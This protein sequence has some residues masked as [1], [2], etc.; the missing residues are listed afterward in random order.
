MNYT[1][2]SELSV[3][4]EP[5]PR[6]LALVKALATHREETRVRANRAK[7]GYVD[8]KFLEAAL[9]APTVDQFLAVL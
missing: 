1:K 6:L 3:G 2:R 8:M 4:A 7:V 9:K 5:T